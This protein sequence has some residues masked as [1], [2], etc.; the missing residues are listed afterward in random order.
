MAKMKD[1]GVEIGKMAVISKH[2]QIIPMI[3]KVLN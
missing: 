2:G 3:D 1:L